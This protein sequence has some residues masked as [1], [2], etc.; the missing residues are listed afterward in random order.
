VS[1]IRIW[2]HVIWSTKNGERIISKDLKKKLLS[3]IRE[4]AKKK[5]IHIDFMDCVE[6]HVH[7]LISL[8]SDQNISKIIQLIKGESS[9]WVNNNKLVNSKFEWQDDYFALSVSESMVDKVRDYIK[10]Q[11]EHHRKQSFTEE[12]NAFIKRYGFDK[13]KRQDLT[14]VK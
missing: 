14:K 13:L 8:G 12:Y 11:E 1:Y 7:I 3:H 9:Y 10:N 2:I 4:N 5:K 6:D